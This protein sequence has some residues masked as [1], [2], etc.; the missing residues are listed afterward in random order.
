MAETFP[1]KLKGRAAASAAFVNWF[2]AFLITLTFETFVMIFGNAMILFIFG[3]ICAISAFFVVL[4]MYET[5]GKT[6]AQ[7][8]EAFGALQNAQLEEVETV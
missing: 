6:L 4:C 8:Q 1:D 2:F 7:I 3:I 5:K